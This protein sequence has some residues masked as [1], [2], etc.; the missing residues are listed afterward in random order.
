[1]LGTVA[2]CR[3]VVFGAA[4]PLLGTVPLCRAGGLLGSRR[5]CG[6]GSG[7]FGRLF[8]GFFGRLFGGLRLLF[9][10]LKVFTEIGNGVLPGEM[11]HHEIQFIA[12]KHRLRLFGFAAKAFLQQRGQLL[13]VYIQVLGDLVQFHFFDH[14][15]SSSS[16]LIIARIPPA[17]FSSQTASIPE[18]L[19]V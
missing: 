15:S 5:L 14:L 2:L 17:K 13:A 7:L 18:F 10:Q 11:L 8:S 1:M 12:G 9:A 4:V 16:S 6:R 19:P 3:A